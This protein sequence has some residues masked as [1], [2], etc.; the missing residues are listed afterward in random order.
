MGNKLEFVETARSRVR[1]ELDHARE[2]SRRVSIPRRVDPRV[3]RSLRLAKKSGIGGNRD[4]VPFERTGTRGSGN[5][6]TAG[7]FP[8]SEITESSPGNTSPEDRWPIPMKMKEAKR[9]KSAASV[10]ERAAADARALVARRS[11]A[12]KQ[13]RIE[14]LSQDAE[15]D[16][17][18]AG[19]APFL[20][21][22]VSPAPAAPAALRRLFFP[23]GWPSRDP[24]PGIMR[25]F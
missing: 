2:I 5:G 15:G 24:R 12:L 13:T 20:P 4:E 6:G 3:R 25:E 16:A 14:V 18:L 21:F 22:S 11:P 1:G 8:G 19:P 17:C 9:E 10:K 7:R 23:G